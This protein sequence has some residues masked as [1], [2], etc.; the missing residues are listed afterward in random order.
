M[1]DLHAR[2]LR[3][4]KVCLVLVDQIECVQNV[5]VT[6]LP[7]RPYVPIVVNMFHA[8]EV[9]RVQKSN[10]TCIP[11]ALLEDRPN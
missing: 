9:Q 11:Y 4:Q 7:E 1:N 2:R 3:R 5:S 6:A 10:E 8:C